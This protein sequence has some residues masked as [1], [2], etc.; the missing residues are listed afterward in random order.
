MRPSR[1][2]GGLWLMDEMTSTRKVRQSLIGQ[3]NNGF[4][5]FSR[6][7]FKL[8]FARDGVSNS[9]VGFRKHQCDGTTSRRIAIDRKI[10][11]FPNTRLDS[12]LSRS[13]IVAAVSTSKNVNCHFKRHSSGPHLSA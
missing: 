9:V 3:R 7:A 5:L 2:I 10:V 13:D 11:V 12:L 6:P 1:L 4:L 8:P